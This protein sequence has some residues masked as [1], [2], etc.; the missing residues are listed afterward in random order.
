MDA[1]HILL[2]RPWQY[3]RCTQHD[4][5]KNTYTVFKDGN[6]FTLLPM[7]EKVV[8]KSTPATLLA[9]KEF[10]IASR[11]SNYILVVFPLLYLAKF[12]GNAADSTIPTVV[13]QL[14][15]EFADVFPP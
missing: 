8:V 13:K 12:D 2:G 4:G 14:L 15:Q 5:R 6:C 9:S 11:E 10:F 7:K 3:N 1:C